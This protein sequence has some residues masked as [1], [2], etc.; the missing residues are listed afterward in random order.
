MSATGAGYDLSPTTFSPDGRVFQVEYAGKAVEKS[1][2]AIGVQCRD[3]VV[4]G[5]EKTIISKMLVKNSNRRIQA[6]DKHCG[7]A[8]CGLA[9]DARQL[10]NK[11]REES[12]SYKSFYGTG[13][14]GQVLADRLA[15]HVHMHTL[16]WYLRPF[17]ASILVAAYDN[18]PGLWMIE[19]SGVCYKY[20][21]CAIGKGRA[22]AK[23]E[24]EKI[25]FE[26]ITCKDAVYEIA[27]IL[28][29]LHDDVKDKPF[30]LELSW[31][32]DDSK[33]QHV[34][35]P[36]K[37]RDEAVERAQAAKKKAEEESDDEMD[38]RPEGGKTDSKPAPKAEEP[39]K[40]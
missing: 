25:K 31:V 16:Y 34:L 13:I 32:C 15:G 29:A 30:E 10:V 35:V 18:A 22:G 23:T 6:V 19:P 40:P 38:T 33:R 28:Y 4:M 17:G 37:M 14:P 8:M 1:G 7:V 26:S 9:A 39:K 5:V 2:T 21:G 12:K 20:K 36:D 24:L 11:G 3:G 27:R